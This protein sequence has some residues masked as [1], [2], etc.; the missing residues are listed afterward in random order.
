VSDR[1][2]ADAMWREALAAHQRDSGV[3]IAERADEHD[4]C[5]DVDE[6]RCFECDDTGRCWACNGYDPGDDLG[7]GCSECDGWGHCWCGAG[8]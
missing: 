1:E 6:E 7:S 5:D 4:E 3:S 2:P 8:S